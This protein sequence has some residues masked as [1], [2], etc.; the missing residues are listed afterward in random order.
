[1][2]HACGSFL[3]RVPASGGGWLPGRLKDESTIP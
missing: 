2:T 3:Q 1:M